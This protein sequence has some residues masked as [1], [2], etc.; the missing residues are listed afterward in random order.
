MNNIK[1]EAQASYNWDYSLQ[2]RAL[3]VSI[4]NALN[5]LEQH[6]K[7]NPLLQNKNLQFTNP[8]AVADYLVL[9]LA[10]E[11]D[12][13]FHVLFLDNQS[14]LIENNKMFSGTID[15]AAVYPRVVARRALEVNAASIILAHNHPS[16]VIE[17]S[18]ADIKITAKLKS[19]LETFDINVLDHFIVGGTKT[20]SFAEHGQI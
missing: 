15:S 17:P 12:E 18:Q 5:M 6:F 13:H 14:R 1:S 16:G 3:G 8:E 9:S 20:Y 2:E 11:K 19:C 4:K 7:N 10:L